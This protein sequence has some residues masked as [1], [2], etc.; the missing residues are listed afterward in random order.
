ME[1][2]RVLFRSVS[3]SRYWTLNPKQGGAWIKFPNV[4][5]EE[6]SVNGVDKFIEHLK[7]N[8]EDF[9]FLKQQLNA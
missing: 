3:Q 6:I 2:R 1:F 5:G 4:D 7:A 8:P 9:E